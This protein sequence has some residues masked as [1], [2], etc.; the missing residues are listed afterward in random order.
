MLTEILIAV[1]ASSGFWAVVQYLIQRKDGKQKQLDE[2][3]DKLN[4]LS[5][6]MATNMA[7]SAR[8][9]ILRFSDELSNGG[10]HSQEYFRQILDDIDTYEEFCANHPK[11]RNSY[12][13]MASDHIRTTYQKLLERHEFGKEGDDERLLDQV[14]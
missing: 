9:H 7:T 1:F 14:G 11:F 6:R 3:C 8:T 2:I 13:V 12:A 10:H 5:E 4:Q